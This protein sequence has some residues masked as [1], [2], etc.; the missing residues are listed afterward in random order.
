MINTGMDDIKMCDSITKIVF[1]MLF[2]HSVS[3]A[4]MYKWTDD[5]GNV[6]YSGSAPVDQKFE[7]IA[8][9]KS[10]DTA[11]AEN[12]LRERLEYTDARRESRSASKA[13][14]E[15]EKADAAQQKKLCQQ[16]NERLMHLIRKPRA[17]LIDEEGNVTRMGEEER[18]DEIKYMQQEISEQCQ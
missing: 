15:K 16:L 3:F 5:N 1:I 17:N 4:E 11:A 6:H 18:Q 10:I 9:V 13:E 7:E 14:K 8:P 12:K 2:F